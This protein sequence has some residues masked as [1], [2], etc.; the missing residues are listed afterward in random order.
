MFI[1]QQQQ[2]NKNGAGY[3]T[4]LAQRSCCLYCSHRRVTHGTLTRTIEITYHSGVIG[5]GVGHLGEL[6][7]ETGA[8]EGLS[9]MLRRTAGEEHVDKVEA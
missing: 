4:N 5:V 9:G 3:E 7:N 8:L 2:E 6:Q 1:E